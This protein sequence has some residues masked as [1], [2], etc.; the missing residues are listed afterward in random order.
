MQSTRIAAERLSPTLMKLNECLERDL[1]ASGTPGASIT[2]IFQGEIWSS[3]AGKLSAVSPIHIEKETLFPT[4]CIKK[5]FISTAIMRARD[6]GLL[7]IR[8]PIE[9]FLPRDAR[10]LQGINIG[11]LLSHCSGL[12]STTLL[13]EKAKSDSLESLVA[14]IAELPRIHKPGQTISYGANGYIILASILEKIYNRPIQDVLERISNLCRR[15]GATNASSKSKSLTASGHYGKTSKADGVFFVPPDTFHGAY[16]AVWDFA[17]MTSEGLADFGWRHIQS[18]RQ[19]DTNLL[20]EDSARL[21]SSYEVDI[22]NGQQAAFGLGWTLWNYGNYGFNGVHYG[23]ASHLRLV[24][25]AGL[26]VALLVNRHWDYSLYNSIFTKILAELGGALGSI[27]KP[28]TEWNTS[29]DIYCGTYKG[30]GRTAV[31]E[32]K[33]NSL[34]LT[35]DWDQETPQLVLDRLAGLGVWYERSLTTEL[36]RGSSAHSFRTEHVGLSFN[37]EGY[38]GIGAVPFLRSGFK[39]MARESG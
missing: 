18:L 24:P 32:Q 31:I 25:N 30:G 35:L 8:D 39:L 38:S 1:K 10:C 29:N 2:V 6:S 13:V 5:V 34:H 21:M 26:A 19:D 17:G 36:V 20:T 3:C 9:R 11:H 28:V 12:D 4:G 27:S 14:Q 33:E 37:F 22:P 23:Y 7:D 16:S 15:N